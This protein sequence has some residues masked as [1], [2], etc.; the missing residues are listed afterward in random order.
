MAAKV[1]AKPTDPGPHNKQWPTVNIVTTKTANTP[2]HLQATGPAAPSTR[3]FYDSGGTVQ[4]L[5]TIHI[6]GYS[7]PG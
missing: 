5:K 2:T 4:G 3:Q 1:T 7:G 6:P